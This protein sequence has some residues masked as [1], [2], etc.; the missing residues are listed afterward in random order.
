[1]A[2]AAKSLVAI[3]ANSNRHRLISLRFARATSAR[4]DEPRRIQMCARFDFADIRC[5][6]MS[7]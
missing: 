4:R 5:A 1:L 7:L 6:A 3:S 2:E